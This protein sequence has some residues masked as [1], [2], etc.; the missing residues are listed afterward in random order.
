M[1]DEHVAVRLFMCPLTDWLSGRNKPY[2]NTGLRKLRHQVQ[3]KYSS[4]DFQC[5]N[6]ALIS[7]HCAILETSLCKWLTRWHV[8]IWAE[9]RN[10]NQSYISQWCNTSRSAGSSLLH[11]SVPTEESLW[12]PQYPL[13]SSDLITL[14][15]QVKC[16]NWLLR[17]W[18]LVW[19]KVDSC[20]LEI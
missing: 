6:K 9:T 2:F 15:C 16:E 1:S 5:C 20:L 13:M 8:F 11:I 17:I 12:N 19:N 7:P 10:K 14:S 4:H 3:R 18:G